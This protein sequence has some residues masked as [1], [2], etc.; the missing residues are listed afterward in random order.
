MLHDSRLHP[1]KP[2]SAPSGSFALLF[3]AVRVTLRASD[4]HDDA[5]VA[6]HSPDKRVVPLVHLVLAGQLH[7]CN[8]PNLYFVN[9]NHGKRV[10]WGG[11]GCKMFFGDCALF[12]FLTLY[13]FLLLGG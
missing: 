8:L 3:K 12:F 10:A 2:G 6:G 4:L 1:L 13:F 11:F 7:R 9:A 5:M